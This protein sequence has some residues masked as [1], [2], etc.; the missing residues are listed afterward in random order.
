MLLAGLSVGLH[1]GAV[2]VI[3]WAEMTLEFS[4]TATLTE[5]LEMTFDG[6]HPCHLCKLVQEHGSPSQEKDKNP[7]K[8]EIK[9]PPVSLWAD[10]LTLGERHFQKSRLIIADFFAPARRD[11]P[12][13]PPPREMLP[14]AIFC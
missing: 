13:L 9:L 1:W 7:S 10:S 12:P 2:Q 6:E 4:R 5:A 14:F 11:P 8:T 3:G